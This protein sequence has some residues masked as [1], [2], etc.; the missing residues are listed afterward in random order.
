MEDTSIYS[1][2]KATVLWLADRPGWAYDAIVKA[3]ALERPEYEHRVHYVCPVKPTNDGMTLWA[4]Y[5][6]ADV[7]VAMF[8]LYVRGIPDRF[9]D[10]TVIMATGFRPFEVAS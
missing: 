6:R 8:I 7:I 5:E 2:K 3:V 9:L 1:R 10:K 4:E